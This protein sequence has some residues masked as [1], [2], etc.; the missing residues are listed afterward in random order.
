MLVA[1]GLL[2]ATVFVATDAPNAHRSTPVPGTVKRDTAA[3]ST[4]IGRRRGGH[5]PISRRRR[6]TVGLVAAA[7]VPILVIVAVLP[8]RDD[9]TVSLV[10]SLQLL[11]VVVIAALAGRWPGVVAA[12]LA[13][14]L[15]SWFLVPPYDSLRIGDRQHEVT[16]VV[17]L[18]TAGLV[19]A[20]VSIAADRAAAAERRQLENETAALTQS[21]AL[22]AS[23]LRAVSHDLRTPLASIKA[24]ASSLREP[25]IVWSDTDRA[26]F[27]ET[28]ETNTDRLTTIITDL[29][30][31]SRLQAGTVV[32]AL[33]D[34]SIEEVVAAALHSIDA[35]DDAVRLD[36]PH[37]LIDVRTDPVLL[38]RVV[39]NLVANAIRWSPASRP[40]RIAA[41]R[42]DERVAL[43]IVDHGPGIAPDQRDQA[44]RP[45]QRLADAG[46]G[47]VGL[48]LAIADQM[49]TVVGAQ[50]TL[51]DTPGGGLTAV[52]D[53]PARRDG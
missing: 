48:G 19:S 4:I 45:F 2:V 15:V 40:V 53:L 27:L 35:G 31:L 44:R 20:L 16:L 18:V 49:S 38:E 11:G 43:A 46:P 14:L 42:A 5:R 34:T 21:D 32:P 3:V 23:L 9:I 29:L 22:R 7:V 52:I 30:D 1:I 36:L 33:T 24:A 39:A 28:I 12:A 13:P 50:L 37:D 10:L 25:D 41:S 6:R 8:W 26:D 17:F 47:G 51:R